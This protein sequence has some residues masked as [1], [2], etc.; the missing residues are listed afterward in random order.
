MK[1]ASWG[2]VGA[3]AYG[4]D[5]WTKTHAYEPL[6]TET[7]AVTLC[8]RGFNPQT[9]RDQLRRQARGQMS[10]SGAHVCDTGDDLAAVECKTCLRALAKARGE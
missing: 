10:H 4:R 7:D 8:G 1:T 3:T 9:D 5:Y 2:I 6:M